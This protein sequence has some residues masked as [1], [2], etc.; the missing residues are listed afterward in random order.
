[1]KN[2]EEL[3]FSDDFMFCKILQDNE[4]LCKELTELVLGRKIGR[5]VKSQS[6][7]ASRL[8]QTVMVS[9]LMCILKTMRK[10]SMILKCKNLTQES[11]R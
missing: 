7:K 10:Q 4:D 3:T 5:I 1:M 11:Y 9:D 6:Q 2:Y 8:Q